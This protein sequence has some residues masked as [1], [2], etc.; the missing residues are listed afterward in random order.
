MIYRQL[1]SV[2][3]L[4]AGFSSVAA[5]QGMVVRP[6]SDVTLAGTSNINHWACR[7]DVFEATIAADVQGPFVMAVNP[8]S[9][10]V[11]VTVPVKSMECGNGWMNRD[12]YDALDAERFPSIDY[13]LVSYAFDRSRMTDARLVAR[14]IGDITVAGVTKRVEIPITAVRRDDGTVAGEGT[15]RLRMTDFGVKP[16][17][18]LF[19]LIRARNDIE[20]SFK[21]L[22]DKS[23]VSALTR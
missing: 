21:V 22:L 19:G 13:V 16:P 2:S 1:L 17:V 15:L 14:A 12:L 11:T 10:K 18:A 7:S 5:A 4:L 6:Q 20:V 9:G 3:A 8:E 23:V